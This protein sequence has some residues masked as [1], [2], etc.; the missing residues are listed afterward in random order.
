M[1]KRMV[2][3]DKFRTGLTVADCNNTAGSYSCECPDDHY[4]NGYDCYPRCPDCGINAF[5][6]FEDPDIDPECTCWPGYKAPGSDPLIECFDENEC[7]QFFTHDCWTTGDFC[8]NTPGTFVCTCPDGYE[9]DEDTMMCI[10]IDE[11]ASNSHRCAP[12]ILEGNFFI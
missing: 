3:K 12:D 4:G 7:E 11:C 1:M 8:I 2:S 6:N 5:C 9:R 10:D